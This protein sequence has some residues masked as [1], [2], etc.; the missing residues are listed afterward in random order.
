MN[1]PTSLRRGLLALLAFTGLLATLHL[2]LAQDQ[3]TSDIVLKILGTERPKIALPDLRGTGAAIDLMPVLNQTLYTDIE[4]SGVFKVQPKSMYPLQVPQRRDDFR[5]PEGNRYGN[6]LY[7]RDWSQPPVEAN[8]LAIGYAAEQSGRLVLFGYLYN[9]NEPDLANAEVFGKMYFGSM[10]DAGARAVAHEFANDILKQFGSR[11]LAG[12]RIF[13]VSNR[14][15]NDEIWTMNFDGT[16][17]KQ[18]TFLRSMSLMPT[19]S[20]DGSLMAFTTFAEGTPT[21]R[22]HS[23]ETQ[24]RRP[25]VNPV[26]SMNATPE[27]SKDN[28]QIFFSS[29]ADGKSTQIYAA[30][31][32]GAGLRRLTFSGA[33]EVSPRVNPKTGAD[34]L[35]VSGRGGTPQ[36][37]KMNIDGANVERLTSGEGEAHNPAWNPDGETM[38]F[39]W[40]RGYEPGNFNIF[41]MD[42]ISRQYTQLTYG[43]GRNENPWW[44]PDGRR[45]VFGSSRSGQSQIWSMLADG[46]QVQQLTTSGRNRMPVWSVK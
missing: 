18:F 34:I 2:S 28:G 41:I 12:T 23:A 42:T 36:I 22:I 24:Q 15:G 1:T 33:V 20:P 21:I 14:T 13:F 25:F 32:N 30:S 44:S 46:T 45:I 16:E 6:G 10:D 31:I 4:M 8:W 29:T 5:P 38:A 37:Y 7:L 27:I 17:Q 43:S 26:A 11:T 39:A 40:S 3:R 35:F 19:V 9:V